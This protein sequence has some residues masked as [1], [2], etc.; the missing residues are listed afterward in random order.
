[1]NSFLELYNS[2]D[3]RL[4]NRDYYTS[5]W[6][7]IKSASD[8]LIPFQF[9]SIDSREAVTISTIDADDS[10][11]DITAKFYGSTKITGW[12][13]TGTGSWSS[14]GNV[15]DAGDA[16]DGDY[17]TS[18]AFTL[19]AGDSLYIELDS[20]KYNTATE[21]DVTLKKGAATIVTLNIGVEGRKWHTVAASGADYTIVILHTGGPDAVATNTPVVVESLIFMSGSYKWYDGSQLYNG[22]LSGVFRLKVA[23]ASKTVYS[24]WIDPCGFTDKTKIEISSSY[25]YGGIKYDEGYEQWIYK[26]ATVR[27]NPKAEITFLGDTLNGKRENEKIT[28]TV[29]YTAKMKCTESEYEALVHGIAGTL[30]ITDKD[31]KVY[32]VQ[33]VELSDPTMYRTNG[34]VELSFVDGNNINVFSRNN[35]SL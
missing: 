30:E 32:D 18:N 28:S 29:R 6:E 12:T 3:Y 23:M 10:E 22:D 1:M 14:T 25:D 5:T 4:T 15:I 24:D 20:T 21:Y 33:N 17:Q 34:I 26:D 16:N 11:T 31:G 13:R 27:R 8:Y 19:A 7:Y 35:T 2:S 9:T